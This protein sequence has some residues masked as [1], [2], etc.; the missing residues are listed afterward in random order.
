MKIQDLLQKRNILVDIQAANKQEL[1]EQMARFLASCHGLPDPDFV[2][3]K[4]FERESDMST[5]VGFGIAIPHTRIEGLE[6][7]HMIAARTDVPIDYDAIDEQP[8]RL[9]FMMASPVNTATLHAQILSRLSGIMA[10]SENREALLKVRN[11]DEFLQVITN[12]ENALG[13]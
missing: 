10:K 11:A 9:V 4:V 2:V 5:G 12:A 1:L 6:R 13:Q 7:A 8:V 3:R